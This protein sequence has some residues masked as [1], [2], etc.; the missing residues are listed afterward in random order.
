MNFGSKQLYQQQNMHEC[1]HPTT[2]NNVLVQF[3]ALTTPKNNERHYSPMNGQR[4][5]RDLH[6]V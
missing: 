3:L 1:V 2:W 5:V 4:Q 6:D